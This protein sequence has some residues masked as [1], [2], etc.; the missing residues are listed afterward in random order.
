LILQDITIR[1]HLGK[2]N[3][4]PLWIPR[5]DADYLVVTC[6]E[7]LR[8]GSIAD[9]TAAGESHETDCVPWGAN[10]RYLVDPSMLKLLEKNKDLL[11]SQ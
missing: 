10:I 2:Q 6:P 7:C 11:P 5:K 3:L 1:R 8:S 9:E 4:A